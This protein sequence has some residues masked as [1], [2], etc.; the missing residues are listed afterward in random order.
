LRLLEEEIAHSADLLRCPELIHVELPQQTLLADVRE[1]GGDHLALSIPDAGWR[2]IKRDTSR[3]GRRDLIE[4]RRRSI[5]AEPASVHVVIDSS[6]T[7][8]A[9]RGVVY[10]RRDSFDYVPVPAEWELAKNVEV[11]SN[12]RFAVQHDREEMDGE[13]VAHVLSALSRFRRQGRHRR[14]LLPAPASRACG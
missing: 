10:E 6:P 2:P 13:L 4:I 12:E 5:V 8:E 3:L 9:P 7:G 14:R 1:R 11:V